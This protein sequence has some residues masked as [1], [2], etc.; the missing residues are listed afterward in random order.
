MPAPRSIDAGPA[1]RLKA[2]TMR[3][4][5]SLRE[6]VDQQIPVG[7]LLPALVMAPL[8]VAGIGLFR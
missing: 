7:D 4:L 5:P 6:K 1:P 8:I 2:Q 3:S